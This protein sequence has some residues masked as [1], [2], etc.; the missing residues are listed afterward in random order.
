MQPNDEE[1]TLNREIGRRLKLARI[2]RGRSF[3]EICTAL[4]VTCFDFLY[5]GL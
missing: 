4:G 1:S 5:Q 3:A 2:N